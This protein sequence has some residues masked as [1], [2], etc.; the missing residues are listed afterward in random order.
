MYIYDIR[1]QI[2]KSVC[3]SCVYVYVL[4]CLDPLSRLAIDS[5]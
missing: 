1:P 5:S 4:Y 2:N 3:L